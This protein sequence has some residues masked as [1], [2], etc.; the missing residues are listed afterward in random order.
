MS[1]K[2]MAFSGV[3]L[4]I[5][6][7]SLSG[8]VL[9]GNKDFS[10]P[11]C[12]AAMKTQSDELTASVDTN[13]L[14]G[15][16]AD[17]GIKATEIDYKSASECLDKYLKEPIINSCEKGEKEKFDA[18]NRPSPEGENLDDNLYLYSPEL[19]CE[20]VYSHASEWIWKNFEAKARGK[21]VKPDEASHYAMTTMNEC[22]WK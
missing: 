22:R 2:V 3:T 18:R 19:S 8:G 10:K 1:I 16:I 6:G 21:V 20:C 9:P 14:C 11:A 12:V 13:G 5:M 15:C 17:L 7:V 4:A